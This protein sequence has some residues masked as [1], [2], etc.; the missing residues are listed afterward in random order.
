[1]NHQINSSPNIIR[2]EVTC[3]VE[4][5]S[6]GMYLPSNIV[7]SDELMS[8]IDSLKNYG[9]PTE[10][11][12][13]KIGIAER[14]VA[15]AEDIPSTLAIKAGTQ[16]LAS[17]GLNSVDKIVFC[18]ISKD[19]EEPS[20]AHTINSKLAL[21]AR[22]CYDISDAC[23]GFIRGLQD[24]IRSIQLGEVETALVVTGETPSKVISNFVD[25]LRAGVES[26]TAKRLLGFLTAGD[27]GGAILLARAELNYKRGFG[28]FHI[29]SNSQLWNMC[30][31][32]KEADGQYAGQ[33]LMG[34]LTAH[35]RRLG[36]QLA[37][38]IMSSPNWI[39]PDHMLSH[40]TGKGSF[41]CLL[42]FGLAP[43]SKWIKT[44]ETLGNLTTATFPV[45]FHMQSNASKFKPGELMG[46]LFNGSG[47]TFGYFDYRF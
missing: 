23:F 33:M 22:D 31:Y 29:K 12:S 18:G 17:A 37:S 8:R 44:Y 16:A 35:G 4:I 36:K 6:S 20:T 13:R 32:R 21:G 7:H 34:K 39:E 11:M 43:E 41:A 27:A 5:H 9:I 30:H 2:N 24:S 45:N 47:L 38:E 46:G 25:Q 1:M 3:G 10:Y 14:R 42:E 19:Q 28:K 15:S 26:S 40:N